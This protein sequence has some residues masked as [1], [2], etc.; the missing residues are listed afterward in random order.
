[1]NVR[2][3]AEKTGEPL[4]TVPTDVSDGPNVTVDESDVLL[5]L[6]WVRTS[7]ED[8]TKAQNDHRKIPP[9][10]GQAEVEEKLR[11]RAVQHC[12]RHLQHPFGIPKRVIAG[13]GTPKRR[14]HGAA[15]VGGS[16][17]FIFSWGVWTWRRLKNLCR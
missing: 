13:C 14:P 12:A 15:G 4:P 16:P 17:Q 8:W 9:S 10:G 6:H 3:T 2:T 1:M 5:K 7:A 11:I